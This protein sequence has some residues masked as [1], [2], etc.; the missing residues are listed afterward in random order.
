MQVIC[1]QDDINILPEKQ[2]KYAFTQDENGKLNLTV[3]RNYAVYGIAAKKESHFY[4]IVADDDELPWWI[5]VDFFT[6]VDNEKPTS[7]CEMKRKDGTLTVTADALFEDY[8]EDIEDG[9]GKG[10]SAF[11]K[12]RKEPDALSLKFT[13]KNLLQLLKDPKTAALNI[14]WDDLLS[15]KETFK[16]IIENYTPEYNYLLGENVVFSEYDRELLIETLEKKA[17]A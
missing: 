7:W 2:R 10:Y 3:G 11:Q 17:R 12:M 1:I 8:A 6:I 13:T 5:P 4:Y 16:Y 15:S 9:T 14:D